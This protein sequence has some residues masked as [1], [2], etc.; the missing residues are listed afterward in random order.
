VRRVELTLLGRFVSAVSAMLGATAL[1][2]TPKRPTFAA[3]PL[4]NKPIA[5][6]VLP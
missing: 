1:T 4:T 5:P 2:R 6:L 3:N